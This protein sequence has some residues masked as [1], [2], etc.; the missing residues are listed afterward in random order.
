MC[1]SGSR[2]PSPRVE[3]RRRHDHRQRREH[4]RDDDP[5][6]PRGLLHA[7]VGDHHH[8]DDRADP[9]AAGP[10]P[11]PRTRRRS[12]PSPT[13]QGHRRQAGGPADHDA[14]PGEEP[15]VIAETLAGVDV[16]S[17]RIRV[18][19]RQLR[20]GG[21]VRVRDDRRDRGPPAA[22]CPLP[23]PQDRGAAKTPAPIMAP[24]P[25][26]TAS[27]VVSRRGELI[28]RAQEPGSSSRRCSR[29][30][31]RG[32]PAED[33]MPPRRPRRA[34]S[35]GPQPPAVRSS[36]PSVGVTEARGRCWSHPTPARR[37][38]K[39][40]TIAVVIEGIEPT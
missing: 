13:G 6:Q 2:T 7:A 36:S 11:G 12:R 17:S 9:R 27:V 37:P 10:G 19:R 35:E 29:E 34:S 26:T 31:R 28:V 3:S 23:R 30:E 8:D 40:A 20:R 32:L 14:P 22:T 16:G 4:Q 24:S 1:V 18:E 21:R 39:M 5:G 38:E 33:R 15:P 25:M